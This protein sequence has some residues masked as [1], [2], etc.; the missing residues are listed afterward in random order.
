MQPPTTVSVIAPLQFAWDHTRRILFEPFDFKKWLVI[1]FS[2]FLASLASYS[3][4]GGNYSGSSSQESSGGGGDFMS[5]LESVF[6]DYAGLVLGLGIFM[7]IM[8]VLLL[9]ALAIALLWV[10]CRGTFM[11]IDNV[12]RNRAEIAAPWKAFSRQ[13]WQLFYF[14][15]TIGVVFICAMIG[16]G[17]VAGVLMATDV[18]VLDNLSP[19]LL[20]AGVGAIA[21]PIITFAVLMF[22]FKHIVVSRMYLKKC[23][24]LEA[25]R[26]GWDLFCSYP[27]EW[28]LYL[29]ISI[30]LGIVNVLLVIVF[31]LF[32]CCIA[33]FPYIHQVVML[34]VFVFMQ[35]YS[36][37]FL[38]QFGTGWNAFPAAPPS[39]S[40]ESY[41]H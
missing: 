29:L 26:D 17:V 11:F 24:L 16:V 5:S 18:L 13:A 30:G 23:G 22:Y 6:G 8:L 7:I 1:G 34:P 15:L 27:L 39:L 4:N 10:S 28:I 19:A 40:T 3:S 2:C 14:Y 25:A 41:V 12:A 36:L 20:A 32:T 37:A 33:L 38:A 35:A 31:C 9:I 21:V